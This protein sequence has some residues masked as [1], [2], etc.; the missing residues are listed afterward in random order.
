MIT[1]TKFWK[2]IVSE[3][4]EI[5]RSRNLTKNVMKIIKE[6]PQNE[7]ESEKKTS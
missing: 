7:T 2:H 4:K 1:K 3:L 6:R 5:E